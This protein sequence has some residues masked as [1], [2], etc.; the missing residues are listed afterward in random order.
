MSKR[1]HFIHFPKFLQCLLVF[2]FG[3]AVHGNLFVTFCEQEILAP[4]S[5][6]IRA[7]GRKH[8]SFLS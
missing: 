6:G 1:D 3:Q 5:P 7:S 4:C 8:K 2:A